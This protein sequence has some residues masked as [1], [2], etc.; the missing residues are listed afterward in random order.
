[1]IDDEPEPD[2]VDAELIAYL[3]GELEASEARSLED[4]LDADPKLRARAEGLKRSY[5]LLDFLPKPEPSPT[6]ATRTMDKIPASGAKPAV[7]DSSATTTT[8]APHSSLALTQVQSRSEFPWAVAAGLFVAVG[9]A[10][11]VG[12]LGTAALRT[13]VFPPAEPREPSTDSLT[14]AEVRVIANLPL[15]AAADDFEYLTQLASPEFFGDE[16]DAPPWLLPSQP[17]EVEKPADPELQTLFRAYR[18]LPAERQEKIR[19]M[20]QRIHALEPPK[21][22][23]ML[24]LLETYAAW[25]HRLPESDRKDV[26]TATSSNKRLEAVREALLKQWI[27]ALPAVHR[28]KLKGLPAEDKAQLLAKLRAD[29]EK[30][31]TEW[32][33]AR[34]QWESIRT[35]KQPWPFT[36][37]SMRKSVIEYVRAVYKPDDPRRARLSTLGPDGGDA[38]RLKDALDRADK[39]E[40]AL[41]GKAVY[42]FSRKYEMLPEPAKGAPIVDYSD[43]SPWPGIVKVMEKRPKLNRAVEQAVGKWPD[44]ALAVHAE[45]GNKPFA[46]FNTLKLGPCQMD[47]FKDDFRRGF[48]ELRRKLNEAEISALKTLEGTWPNYPRELVRLAKVHD[49]SLPGVMPPGPPNLWEKTYNSPR[50]PMRP[51]G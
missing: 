10:L 8:P 22:D 19:T 46:T 31:R 39:G 42:D 18:E 48:G 38:A 14:V 7:S 41:L 40:W 17:L 36:D 33:V 45:I 27:A 37:E 15:Y 34:I 43:L 3:D 1:V 44:F 25:L 23:R 29:D 2:P 13:F 50:Q 26:L 47:E 5:D 9:L 49:V 28:A 20:D 21:R 11:G 51:G 6:F 24:R 30:Q 35:N 4:R 32:T 16:L 12:Y